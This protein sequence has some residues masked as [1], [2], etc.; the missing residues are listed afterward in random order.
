MESHL[1]G[2]ERSEKVN[3]L[4][5]RHESRTALWNLKNSFGVLE[6]SVNKTLDYGIPPDLSD[7][8]FKGSSVKVPVR[9]KL[10]TGYVIAVNGATDC[11]KVLPV[12]AVL[13][14]NGL[15]SSGLFELAVWMAGYYCAPLRNVLKAIFPPS[16]RKDGKHKQQL[17]VM[18][19]KTREELKEHCIKIRERYPAQ[20]SVLDE[21][22]LVKKG[23]LLSELLE[24]TG[25]SRA[26]VDTL[27]KKGFVVLDTVRV[28]RSPLVTRN[29]SR[30]NLKL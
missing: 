14:E 28:D 22:L 30:A 19:G 25:G 16:I 11:K 10:H 26:P 2:S 15:L 27:A 4:P 20:A 7:K 24:K 18:R 12:S 5:I 17:Y 21:M 13:P 23:I 9:G 29:I 8:V 1:R 3:L 6:I